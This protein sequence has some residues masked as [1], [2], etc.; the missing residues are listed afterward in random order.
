MD[1]EPDVP[2]EETAPLKMLELAA[3]PTHRRITLP[4]RISWRIL[5]EL[6]DAMEQT[7]HI[8]HAAHGHDDG[9]GHGDPRM[10]T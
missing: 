2:G 8:S 7:E 4:T 5:M 10:G 1:D 6:K 9:G 3:K